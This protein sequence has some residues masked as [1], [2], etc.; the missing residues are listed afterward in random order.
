[1]FPHNNT[2]I[3][4]IEVVGFTNTNWGGDKDDDKST[5]SLV[6][7]IEGAPVHWSLKKE[8]V[9]VLSTS[10]AEYVAFAMCACP[11]TWLDKLLIELK[12]NHDVRMKLFVDNNSAIN[13]S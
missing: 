6:F 9:V 3:Q 7:F 8:Q 2:P 4:K 11:T 5:A 10:E 1:L 13:L 12:L